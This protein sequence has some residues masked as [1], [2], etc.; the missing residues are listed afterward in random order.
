M[1]DCDVLP[2]DYRCENE[3]NPDVLCITLIKDM[4]GEETQIYILRVAWKIWKQRIFGFS[5]ITWFSYA[6]CGEAFICV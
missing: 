4:G 1:L 6:Q 3:L 2:V 5:W